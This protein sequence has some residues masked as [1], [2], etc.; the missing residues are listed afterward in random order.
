MK[1]PNTV[2]PKSFD[3][4]AW[5]DPNRILAAYR[6]GY[7]AAQKQLPFIAPIS[8][9][10]GEEAAWERGYLDSRAET[11]AQF[12]PTGKFICLA[13]GTVQDGSTLYPD[14]TTLHETWICSDP[15][16]GGVC[17]RKITEK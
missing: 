6:A 7:R 8:S 15:E 3:P 2:H 11:I 4:R 13:C 12:K 10:L 17:V 1:D 5:S 9:T 14:P 16:C